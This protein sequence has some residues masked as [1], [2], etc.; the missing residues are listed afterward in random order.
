[1]TDL[2]A[3]GIAHPNIAFIK[4]WGNRDDGLRVPA[5]GSIS[6]NLAELSAR[7]S[8]TFE[9]GLARDEFLLNNRPA[10]ENQ[11]LRVSSILSLVREMV[12][13]DLRARVESTNDFPAGSGIAS[14]AAGFAALAVAASQAAGLSLSE[15]DLSRLARRGSGSA[16]RSVPDGFVEWLPGTDDASSI[17]VS[18][19]PPEH[20]DLLDV[21]A[22][23]D[24][25]HKKTGSTEGHALA[26]TSPLQAGRLADTPRRLDLCRKAVL[27]RNF[28]ALAAV[29]EHDCL[30]MHAVMMT[31]QP[32][33]FYWQPATLQLMQLVTDWRAAG[34]KVA[35][36]ID[37]GPNLHLI[38]PAESLPA[39]RSELH[40]L[41]IVEDLYVT[42]PGR[43]AHILP[44]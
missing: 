11:R 5:N 4:Y 29:I 22:V 13:M 36:T 35:Y 20:W 33:L 38:A 40:R 37:A 44:L 27:E 26:P 17:S 1:M 12:G 30:I 19:A 31:S 25:G 21:V 14:S 18:I 16:S 8:V 23:L 24:P 41:A 15:A 7:T 10:E 39:L 6:M 2:T 32:A 43:G 42:H 34:L 28:D 9:D 3:T